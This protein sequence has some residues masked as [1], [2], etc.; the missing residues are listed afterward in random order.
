MKKSTG[1]FLIVIF[2]SIILAAGCTSK[3]QESTSPTSMQTSNSVPQSE[4]LKVSS[5]DHSFTFY[6][7][8]LTVMNSADSPHGK[9]L[10]FY[11]NVL[12][13]GNTAGSL[14]CNGGVVDYAG[15]TTNDAVAIETPLL[16]PGHSTAIEDNI[17]FQSVSSDQYQALSKP[18]SYQ[19]TCFDDSS[20]TID[21]SKKLNAQWN[22]NPLN[23]EILAE[24]T[25]KD[26]STINPSNRVTLFNAGWPT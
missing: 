26:E 16:Y 22:I 21:F 3:S 24:P 5:R 20:G 18:F 10:D 11:I 4:S 2:A 12:N 1:L 7:L 17:Y 15:V 13:N 23:A 6:G 19:L 14:L 9:K 8:N 25:L